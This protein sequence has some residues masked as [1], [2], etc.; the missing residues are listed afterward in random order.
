[1]SGIRSLI[2]DAEVDQVVDT[3]RRPELN[4]TVSGGRFED[5]SARN[6]MRTPE[7]DALTFGGDIQN[8]LLQPQGVSPQL[9][10]LLGA[11]PFARMERR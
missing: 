11:P 5:E 8:S 10:M 1:M 7:Q 9:D 6:Q 2:P 4:Q 3:V